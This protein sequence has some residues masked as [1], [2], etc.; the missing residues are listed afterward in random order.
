MIGWIKD[1]PDWT[2]GLALG[3]AAW[4]SVGYAVLAPRAMENDLVRD[5]YPACLSQLE[6]E[7]ANAIEQATQ[8]KERDIENRRAEATRILKIRQRELREAKTQIDLYGSITRTFNE[9]GLGAIVPNVLPKVDVPSRGQVERLER[10]VA[11]KLKAIN[12]PVEI[13]FPRAPSEDLMKTCACAGI[14]AVAG[15][16]TNYAISV[17]SFRL[18]SPA[19]ISSLKQKTAEAL[20]V[21]SCGE[22]AWESFR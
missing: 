16:R 14:Q 15:Q 18:I 7:Q 17:A 22:P 2:I 3:G 21:K 11:E 4:F 6:S 12:L 19:E 5:V 20:R 13:S 1:L 10:E 8:Q 9:S